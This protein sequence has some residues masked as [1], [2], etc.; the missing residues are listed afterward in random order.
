V[1]KNR[2]KGLMFGPQSK[3]VTPLRFKEPDLERFSAAPD[4]ALIA[5]HY[6]DD[7]VRAREGGDDREEWRFIEL[8][9]QSGLFALEN[10]D[11][12]KVA[13]YF[14]LIGQK[15][16][17]LEYGDVAAGAISRFAKERASRRKGL[18]EREICLDSLKRKAQEIA[19]RAWADDLKQEV[20]IT[21][22]ASFVWPHLV[23]YVDKSPGLLKAR[24]YKYLPNSSDGLKPWL[25]EVDPGWGSKRGAPR[26]KR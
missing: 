26:K 15:T 21:E 20:R 12:D 3:K 1:S 25:R 17:Q 11:L 22:M 16:A 8:A 2:L 9:C 23:E 19:V 5:C 7:R 13:Y 14:Y 18:I 24:L 4:A 10:Q 6:L